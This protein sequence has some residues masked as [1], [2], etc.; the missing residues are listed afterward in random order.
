MDCPATKGC[1]IAK[2]LDSESPQWVR[3]RPLAS[4]A[5]F[6]TSKVRDCSLEEEIGCEESTDADGS[7]S[8]QGKTQSPRR[9]FNSYF[10]STQT[11]LAC[12]CKTELC[13]ENWVA[14]GSSTTNQGC[15]T[16]SCVTCHAFKLNY[17]KNVHQL[18]DS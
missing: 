8:V 7:V 5:H 11:V 9:P 4:T 16:F 17:I 18:L 3:S 2:T 15:A 1:R 6:V 10:F 12:I 13:N 14:A